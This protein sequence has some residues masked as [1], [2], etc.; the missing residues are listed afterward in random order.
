M[1]THKGDEKCPLI[2]CKQTAVVVV[3]IN[4]IGQQHAVLTDVLPFFSLHTL[5]YTSVS[6][7]RCISIVCSV[8]K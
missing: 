2:V 3:C 7:T 8:S 1:K 5:P 4:T 6:L